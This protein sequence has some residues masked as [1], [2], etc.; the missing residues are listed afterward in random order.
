MAEGTRRYQ[1]I[2]CN[3]RNNAAD[4]PAQKTGRFQSGRCPSLGN[5][6]QPYTKPAN[7]SAGLGRVNALTVTVTI[8]HTS[9]DHSPRYMFS[10]I[11]LA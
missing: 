3:K 4:I 6:V 1:K 2:H 10:A 5:C 8:T 11:S 9:H 7:S